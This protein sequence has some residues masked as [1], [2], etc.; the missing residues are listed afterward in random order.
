MNAFDRF[1]FASRDPVGGSALV[2][3]DTV[4]PACGRLLAF[5]SGPENLHGVRQVGTPPSLLQL[6]VDHVS[7]VR[8]AGAG[9]G[10]D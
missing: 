10:R 3:T 7:D 2:T 4:A 1:F 6:N 9:G 8:F 5:T